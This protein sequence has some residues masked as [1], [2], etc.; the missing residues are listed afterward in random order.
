MIVDRIES[1]Y[2][3]IERSDGSVFDVPLELL[4]VG[5]SA[6]SILIITQDGYKL[7]NEREESLRK[8]LAARTGK[9]FTKR[10]TE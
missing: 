4:P 8:Q 9:L 5:T 10:N 1:G 6:G 2:A 3:V 7:D